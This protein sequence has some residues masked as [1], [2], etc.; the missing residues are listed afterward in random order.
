FPFSNINKIKT[1]LKQVASTNVEEVKKFFTKYDYKQSGKVPF[2]LF[3]SLLI[4]VSGDELT[5]H[6][7]LTVARHHRIQ[8]KVEVS[9]EAIQSEAHDLLRKNNF[10][11]FRKLETLC[12]HRDVDRKGW[13]YPEQVRSVCHSLK[14]PL[15]DD[16]LN[17]LWARLQKDQ[18]GD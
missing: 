10:D 6:E 12:Y 15:T 9:L 16:T 1:K 2:E 3:R 8:E 4:K 5:E 17:E 13:L 7:I 18:F 11:G 14:M